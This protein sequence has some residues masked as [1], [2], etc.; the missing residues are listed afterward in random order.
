MTI[1]H[2]VLG[3]V[4]RVGMQPLTQVCDR[5][6]VNDLGGFPGVAKSKR[7]LDGMLELLAVET[8][9]MPAECMFVPKSTFPGSR[10]QEPFF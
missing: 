3:E 9:V 6:P 7:H 8:V 5:V 2:A 10:I 4:V 1:L